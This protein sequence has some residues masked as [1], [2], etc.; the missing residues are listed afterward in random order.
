MKAVVSPGQFVTVLL[1]SE[2]APQQVPFQTLVHQVFE[3]EIIV[4]EVASRDGYAS[5]TR[6]TSEVGDV[7][8]L[9]EYSSPNGKAWHVK[10]LE[11]Q[12]PSGNNILVDSFIVAK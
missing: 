9:Y 10:V 3:H 5:I 4:S 11:L 7:E 1:D 12:D 6:N 8:F 2:N